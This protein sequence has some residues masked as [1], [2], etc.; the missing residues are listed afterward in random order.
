MNKFSSVILIPYLKSS[1]SHF[2][3]VS[4]DSPIY[5]KGYLPVCVG[6]SLSQLSCR[7]FFI[8]HS[9][10]QIKFCFF[11]SRRSRRVV[12]RLKSKSIEFRADIG[13]GQNL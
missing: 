2:N 10:L 7:G 8:V 1:M 13:G 4:L 3:L 5:R 11:W 12:S 6:Q 9:R